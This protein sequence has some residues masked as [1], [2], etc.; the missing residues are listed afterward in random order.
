M[1]VNQANVRKLMLT[2]TAKANFQHR[3][4]SAQDTSIGITGCV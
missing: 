2:T 4:A 1:Q 3:S